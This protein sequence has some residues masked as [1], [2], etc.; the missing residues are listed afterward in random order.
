MNKYSFII[1]FI[2]VIILTL[3]LP[4][5][6][7]RASALIGD[8]N[9]DGHV[10]VL[11]YLIWVSRYNQTADSGPPEG[12]FNSDSKA[13]GVDYNLWLSNFGSGGISPSPTPTDGSM[14]IIS[15]YVYW[16]GITGRLCLGEDNFADWT[17]AGSLAPGQ[18]WSYAPQFP[19]CN[20]NPRVNTANVSWTGSQLQLSIFNPGYDIYIK[21]ASQEGKTLTGKNVSNTSAAC[22]FVNSSSDAVYPPGNLW[23]DG[24]LPH[25]VVTVK[26]TGTTTATNIT[27][28]GRSMMNWTEAYYSQCMNS[29]ADRDGWSDTEEESM[30]LYALDG[31][32][33][34]NGTD[35]L[36]YTPGMEINGFIPITRVYTPDLNNDS[37]IDQSDVDLI[38]QYVGQGTGWLISQVSST[39]HPPADFP[40]L[41]AG[42]RRYD[43]NMDGYVDQQDVTIIRNLLGTPIPMTQ[44]TITPWVKI[45][46][47]ENTT[48]PRI[49]SRGSAIYLGANAW[50]NSAISRVEFYVNDRLA[51]TAI[52]PNDLKTQSY[53]Y[54]MGLF[55]IPW[56]VPNKTGTYA[57][58]AKIYDAAGNSSASAPFALTV[59]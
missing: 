3:L 58:S 38:F 11:D 13:D 9:N 18:S 44:D 12:D 41:K 17:A 35:Y 16:S 48:N 55:H 25:Y 23:L 47:V 6:A 45:L 36:R 49:A 15:D 37:V 59:Q 51:G 24:V 5:Q 56:S 57:I 32:N 7:I 22:I 26:N 4:R 20:N 21:D 2:G 27:L 14:K 30:N 50:D 29:D 39:S 42:W 10:D 19:D 34:A 46:G 28:K 43:L 8:A 1:L 52:Q 54:P 31:N 53:T 40:P 33:L